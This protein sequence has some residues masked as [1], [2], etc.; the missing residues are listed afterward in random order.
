MR[1]GRPGTRAWPETPPPLTGLWSRTPVTND[2]RKS[3]CSSGDTVTSPLMEC[4]AAA[5]CAD[6]QPP[7]AGAGGEA[8]HS[9]AGTRG[10]PGREVGSPE[11][12]EFGPPTWTSITGRGSP[13][14]TRR[15]QQG[16]PVGPEKGRCGRHRDWGTT[17]KRPVQQQTL[18]QSRSL[19]SG[20]P[21]AIT[22]PVPVTVTLEGRAAGS[23]GTR[24]QG[25]RR[26]RAPDCELCPRVPVK[27]PAVRPDGVSPGPPHPPGHQRKPGRGA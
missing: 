15:R 20:S 19:I 22:V 14:R 27:G 2:K 6:T 12:P 10:W 4:Q 8:L 11:T 13:A 5:K 17:R 18:P 7:R 24:Q 23:P 3:C 25:H 9:L 1:G 26:P 21:G 16:R